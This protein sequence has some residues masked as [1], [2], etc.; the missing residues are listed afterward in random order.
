MTNHEAR[1][2]ALGGI[3]AVESQPAAREHIPKRKSANVSSKRGIAG[4]YMV[5]GVPSVRV[6]VRWADEGYKTNESYHIPHPKTSYH[7]DVRQTLH[8]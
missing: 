7:L 3:A 4:F 5:V 8:R 6:P 1:G 2:V